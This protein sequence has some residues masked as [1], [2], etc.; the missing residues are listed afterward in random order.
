M[1]A[2]DE[3][4]SSGGMPGEAE[5]RRHLEQI[6]SPRQKRD[7]KVRIVLVGQGPKRGG[8]MLELGTFIAPGA[9]QST[10]SHATIQKISHPD[11]GDALSNWI[12]YKIL[13]IRF[14]VEN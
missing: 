14:Y 1:V 5:F 10:F 8:A 11:R 9:L 2:A 4:I 6:V 13:E 3:L 7:L 12:Y